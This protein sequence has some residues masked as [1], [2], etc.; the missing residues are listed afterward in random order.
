[1]SLPQQRIG[2]DLK[3]KTP[4]RT[5]IAGQRLAP[6]PSLER[7]RKKPEE[8]SDGQDEVDVEGHK[9]IVGLNGGRLRLPAGVCG[10]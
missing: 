3:K 8:P 4:A 9:S 2:D 5:V 10:A 1:M 6:V 7:K